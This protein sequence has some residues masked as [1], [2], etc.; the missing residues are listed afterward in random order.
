MDSEWVGRA[1]IIAEAVS[2]FLI[3]PEILGPER[4]KGAERAL[5]EGLDSPLMRRAAFGVWAAFWIVL[6]LPVSLVWWPIVVFVFGISWWKFGALLAAIHLSWFSS[7]VCRGVVRRPL[8]DQPV[9]SARLF[10]GLGRMARFS[11]VVLNPFEF[12]RIMKPSFSQW[13]FWMLGIPFHIVAFLSYFIL[14][15]TI[16]AL[17]HLQQRLLAGQNALRAL[18]FGTGA[19]LLFGGL[20]VQFYATF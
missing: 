19:F 6:F 1:G 15:A 14:P 11:T 20:A 3:A 7:Y 4:L 16:V 18:V 2:F 8:F 5:A 10:D 12:G 9:E 17:I 13:L